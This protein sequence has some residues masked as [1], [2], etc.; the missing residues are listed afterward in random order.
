MRGQRVE[1]SVLSLTEWPRRASMSG[2]MR[3]AN[4]GPHLKNLERSLTEPECGR[5]SFCQ[6]KRRGRRT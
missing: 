3:R 2:M 4:W 1:W 6:I 5:G